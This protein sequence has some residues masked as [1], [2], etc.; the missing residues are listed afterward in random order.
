MELFDIYFVK[1]GQVLRNCFRP[2][3]VSYM[4]VTDI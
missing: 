3:I 2:E 1:F 4:Q